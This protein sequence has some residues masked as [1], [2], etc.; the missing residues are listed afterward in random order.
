MQLLVWRCLG[1]THATAW[2]HAQE[3]TRLGCRWEAERVLGARR[4]PGGPILPQLLQMYFSLRMGVV[5]QSQVNTDKLHQIHQLHQPPELNTDNFSSF[6][7]HPRLC[8]S[9]SLLSLQKRVCSVPATSLI[10]IFCRKTTVSWL[11]AASSQAVDALALF[12][13]PR[14]QKPAKP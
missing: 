1:W 9:V 5:G 10:C 4:N 7:L 6:H 8:P 11:A 14:R 2:Q 13:L 3:R 12:T